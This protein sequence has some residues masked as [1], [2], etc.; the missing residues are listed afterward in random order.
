MDKNHNKDI[1]NILLES[2]EENK[3][4]IES[5]KNNMINATEKGTSTSSSQVTN[6][7]ADVG[8]EL[9]EKELDMALMN[10]E[11]DIEKKIENAINRVECGDYNK[12]SQCSYNIERERL[13]I[14]PYTDVC[15]S[16]AK[17]NSMPNIEVRN[18]YIS[19]ASIE[20]FYD[21]YNELEERGSYESEE[22]IINLQSSDCIAS[23]CVEK[24]EEI[25]NQQYRDQF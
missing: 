18:D 9:F 12:C 7:P 1:K 11:K 25:S 23:G 19:E 5:L 22:N 8:S 10:S 13:E 15:A 21:M 14:L 17:S 2:M 6:H 16:C 4:T 20:N 3:K 24:V